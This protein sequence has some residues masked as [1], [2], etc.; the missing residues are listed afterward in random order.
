MG[1]G[2]G[3]VGILLAVGLIGLLGVGCSVGGSVVAGRVGSVES[4]VPVAAPV[5]PTA[6]RSTVRSTPEATPKAPVP[7]IVKKVV[8]ETR[9]VPFQRVSVEDAALE[10]GRT[11]VTTNGKPGVRRLTF[12]LTITNGV[13]THKRLVQQ[14]VVTQPVTQVTAVGTKVA[15]EPAGDCDPNYSGGCVPVASDVDCAGGSGNGPAYVEGPVTVVGTD[16]YGLD[17]DKDGVGCED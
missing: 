8:E 5:T 2:G 14:I 9:Q 10:T 11:V 16:V 15:Q 4:Q 13:Q 17:R 7:V 12:E 1:V 3:R 6:V